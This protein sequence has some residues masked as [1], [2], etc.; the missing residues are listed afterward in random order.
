ME[1]VNKKIIDLNSDFMD[2]LY[3]DHDAFLDRQIY[4]LVKEETTEEKQIEFATNLL[5]MK[6]LSKKD[7]ALAT[8]L[9]LEDVEELAKELEQE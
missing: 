4:Y 2:G 8:G 5:K 9:S 1:K 6:K 7:I 3:Y